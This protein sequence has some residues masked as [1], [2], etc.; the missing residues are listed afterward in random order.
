MRHATRLAADRH[1]HILLKGVLFWAAFVI[2]GVLGIRL[3]D[4]VVARSAERLTISL[5]NDAQLA[6]TWIGNG[7]T[8]RNQLHGDWLEADLWTSGP[9]PRLLRS[10]TLRRGQGQGLLHLRHVFAGDDLG[11]P[12]LVL[13]GSLL[14]LQLSADETR[15]TTRL[16]FR[17]MS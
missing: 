5:P 8:L 13:S 7:M 4:G 15:R 16:S 11:R 2:L 12:T 9:R 14:T 6:G 3:L 17:H 1:S 10:F